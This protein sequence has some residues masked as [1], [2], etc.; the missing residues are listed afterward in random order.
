MKNTQFYLNTDVRYY[1]NDNKNNHQV[2]H[3][4]TFSKAIFIIGA[5]FNAKGEI[6]GNSR[7]P[8]YFDKIDISLL[9]LKNIH[10]SN[11]MIFSAE[12]APGD[13]RFTKKLN[14]YIKNNPVFENEYI[15]DPVKEGK[16]LTLLSCNTNNFFDVTI[17]DSDSEELTQKERDLIGPKICQFRIA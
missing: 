7:D 8:S 14:I 12:I 2:I 10:N 11:K 4:E 1:H 3:V 16:E 13:S 9:T 5:C 15:Y 6:Y 17:Y